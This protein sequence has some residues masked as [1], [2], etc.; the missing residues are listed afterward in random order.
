MIP[1]LLRFAAFHPR[2]VAA[3]LAAYWRLL[4]EELRHAGARFVWGLALSTVAAI[5]LLA[6]AILA[7]VAIMLG[8]TVPA[9]DEGIRWMLYVVPLV[10]VGVAAA[11]IVGVVMAWRRP[12]LVRIQALWKADVQLMRDPPSERGDRG[13]WWPVVARAAV[14]LATTILDRGR[15]RPP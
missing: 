8:A 5:C 3:R 4:R 6:A 14:A 12:S 13:G 1:G 7:G 11:C 2:V 15:P 9:T 10:P